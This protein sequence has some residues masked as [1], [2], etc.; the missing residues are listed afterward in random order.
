MYVCIYIDNVLH[1]SPDQLK[2]ECPKPPLSAYMLFCK[3]KRLKV[4]Q[5]HPNMSAKEV[6]VKLSQKWKSMGEEDKV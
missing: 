5:R 1:F 3:V 2:M 4:H 6:T